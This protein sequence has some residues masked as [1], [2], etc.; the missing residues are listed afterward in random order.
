MSPF[1]IAGVGLLWV[2]GGTQASMQLD[3][4]AYVGLVAAG[5][6]VQLGWP[7]GQQEI[8]CHSQ[9]V[10]SCRQEQVYFMRPERSRIQRLLHACF[11]ALCVLQMVLWMLHRVVLSLCH[12]PLG[13]QVK[14]PLWLQFGRR[15]AAALEAWT[16]CSASDAELTQQRCPAPGYV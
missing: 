10:G 4:R 13:T 8:T 11:W 5:D 3:P 14:L 6:K 2:D 16:L 9:D 15:G 12:V 1:S 7:V